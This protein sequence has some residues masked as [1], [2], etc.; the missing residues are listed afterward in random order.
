MTAGTILAI[1]GGLFLPIVLDLLNLAFKGLGKWSAG[2]A[3][4]AN[5]RF[6]DRLEKIPR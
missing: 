2:L 3:T 4:Y 5:A 1:F 6:G